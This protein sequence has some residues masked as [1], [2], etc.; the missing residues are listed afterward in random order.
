MAAIQNVYKLKVNQST[1]YCKHY[2][3]DLK[4]WFPFCLNASSDTV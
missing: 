3:K 4:A 1:P 2:N